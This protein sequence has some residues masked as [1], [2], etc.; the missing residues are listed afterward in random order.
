MTFKAFEKMACAEVSIVD[1]NTQEQ[2]ETFIVGFGGP[3]T[4]LPGIVVGMVTQTTVTIMDNDAT[5]G[6]R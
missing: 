1:D 6:K 3:I 5:T 4:Q 2:P